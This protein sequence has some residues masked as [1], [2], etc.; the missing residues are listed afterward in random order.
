[1]HALWFE[2]HFVPLESSTKN[3]DLKKQLCK[4]RAQ[5]ICDALTY[6]PKPN[7]DFAG[8]GLEVP[9]QTPDGRIAGRVDAIR[10]GSVGVSIIDFKSGPLEDRP[11][12][13]GRPEIKENYA[14]QMKLYAAVYHA[15]RGTWPAVLCLV[16]IDGTSRQ[17]AFNP[18]ECIILLQ[19][20]RRI[21]NRINCTVRDLSSSYDE[22]L[23][24]LASPSPQNCSACLYRPCC[25]PYWNKRAVESG[26]WPN[27]IKGELLSCEKYAQDKLF[28]QV[29]TGHS[30]SAVSIRGLDVNRHPGIND[31]QGQVAVFDLRR[32]HVEESFK[33]GQ[34]TTVYKLR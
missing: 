31:A 9:L 14:T 29:S 30:S 7:R 16:A 12:E 21:L 23:R 22:L 2:R 10:A 8:R 24:I 3:F 17:V 18:N 13:G 20:A 6:T 4:A 34:F 33:G 28:I 5:E 19:Q 11:G 32:D 1:M 15:C 26:E 27:D 25:P